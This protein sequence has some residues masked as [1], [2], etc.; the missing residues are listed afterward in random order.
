[1]A[2]MTKNIVE[3]AGGLVRVEVDYDSATLRIS[4][5]RVV[6]ASAQA[7][8]V[9]AVRLSDGL[10]YSS[11]FGAGTTFSS[12]PTKASTKLEY[13]VNAKGA[14]DGISVEALYPYP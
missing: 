3:F 4:A 5:I 14:L 8:W 12:I 7:C 10:Q 1:M 11:R 6:N 2:T 13:F 9:R